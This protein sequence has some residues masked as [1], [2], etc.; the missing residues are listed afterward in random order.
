MYAAYYCPVLKSAHNNCKFPTTHLIRISPCDLR[1]GLVCADLQVKPGSTMDLIG[2]DPAPFT[3]SSL[4]PTNLP[5]CGR[6]IATY[7]RARVTVIGFEKGRLLLAAMTLS[8][9]APLRN[10]NRREDTHISIRGSALR[11]AGLVKCPVSGINLFQLPKDE[12]GHSSGRLAAMIRSATLA[13]AV[14]HTRRLM[15]GTINIARSSRYREYHA[16]PLL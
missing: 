11:S 16:T 7:H 4:T 9:C 12:A 13:P 6:L 14:L 1:A 10:V 3:S 15:K 8:Y 2:P 5:H